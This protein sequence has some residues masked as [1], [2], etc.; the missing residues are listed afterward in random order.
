MLAIR[1]YDWSCR[2]LQ[3][4]LGRTTEKEVGSKVVRTAEAGRTRGTNRTLGNIGCPRVTKM[5][6]WVKP[7]K[8]VLNARGRGPLDGRRTLT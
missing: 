5:P 1:Y 8:F 2:S 4:S 3:R 7:R 6:E